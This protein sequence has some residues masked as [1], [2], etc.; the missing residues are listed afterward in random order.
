MEE[1]ES[2]KATPL[3]TA[4]AAMG[5][6][7]AAAVAAAEAAGATSAMAAVAGLAASGP[8]STLRRRTL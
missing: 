5:E 4:G 3:L 6:G 2:E 7:T 1:E 8:K